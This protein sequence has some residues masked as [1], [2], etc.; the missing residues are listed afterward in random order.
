MFSFFTKDGKREWERERE[1]K[2][3]GGKEVDRGVGKVKAVA[4]GY[5]WEKH[6]KN[7]RKVWANNRK[8]K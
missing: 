5:R 8:S 1:K 2:K 4:G 6:Q 3:G 7:G